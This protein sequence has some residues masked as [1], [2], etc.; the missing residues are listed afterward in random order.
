MG[1]VHDND[2]I[3]ICKQNMKKQCIHSDSTLA[4]FAVF[5]FACVSFLANELH[6]K[7][8]WKVQRESVTVTVK[9]HANNIH[10]YI[11]K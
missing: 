10:I 7:Y 11:M 6:W 9:K 1:G 4:L 5:V 3:E 2:G 8:E